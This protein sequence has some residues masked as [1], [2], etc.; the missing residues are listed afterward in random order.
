MTSNRR[1]GLSL[2]MLDGIYIWWSKW[3]WHHSNRGVL[4]FIS[5]VKWILQKFWMSPVVFWI[6]VLFTRNEQTTHLPGVCCAPNTFFV[7][8]I[9]LAENIFSPQRRRNSYQHTQKQTS[10]WLLYSNKSALVSRLE[11]VHA[12]LFPGVCYVV[13]LHS[14][15][16]EGQFWCHKQNKN[17][18]SSLPDS[19]NKKM[20]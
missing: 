20:Q 15:P 13:L 11:C 17:G 19:Y 7:F 1:R 9:L 5:V 14:M 3:M 8:H 2:G 4:G 12:N 16:I 10:F 6:T 18:S